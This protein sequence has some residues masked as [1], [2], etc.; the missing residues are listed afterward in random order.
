MN[1]F[2]NANRSKLRFDSA[3]GQ[4]SIEDLWDLSLPSLDIVAK[5]VYKKLKD[6]TEVS[7]IEKK[8][9]TNT[10]LELKLTI[11][12]YIIKTKMDEAEIAKIKAEKKTQVEFLKNLLVEKKADQMKGMTAKQ[13]ESQIKALE[14]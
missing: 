10:E 1:I 5:T 7:F 9:S 14:A 12:K 8:S 3:K 2:E 4:L 11:V 13:I 6:E